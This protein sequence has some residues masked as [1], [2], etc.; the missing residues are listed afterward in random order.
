MITFTNMGNAMHFF[1]DNVSFV[2]ITVK[3]FKNAQFP[4]LLVDCF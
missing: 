2:L 1:G 4:P 3:I